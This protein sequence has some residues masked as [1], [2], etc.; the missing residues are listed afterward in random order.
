M[1]LPPPIGV[2]LSG[3]NSVID[4]LVFLAC[5]RTKRSWLGWRNMASFSFSSRKHLTKTV[6]CPE[7]T[8]LRQH[9]EVALRHWGR[10][11]FSPNAYLVGK[12]AQ[13]AAE[14]KQKAFDERNAAKERLSSHKLSCTTCNP[15]LKRID[16]S[17]N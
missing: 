6:R 13:Q 15:T 14:L 3:S 2:A 11:L 5:S 1:T 16:R 10:T 9:Y 8:R 12:T 4:A 17:V 7:Y